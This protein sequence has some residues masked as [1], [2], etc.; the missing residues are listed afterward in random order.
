METRTWNP[1]PSLYLSKFFNFENFTSSWFLLLRRHFYLVYAISCLIAVKKLD[2]QTEVWNEEQFYTS[3]SMLYAIELDSS[4]LIW[5]WASSHCTKSAGS[6]IFRI[7]HSCKIALRNDAKVIGGSL[8]YL[9]VKL[10]TNEEKSSDT[11]PIASLCAPLHSKCRDKPQH[12][13]LQE[14]LL[15]VWL[16]WHCRSLD[17]H[18][19]IRLPLPAVLV[20]HGQPASLR[21]THS[22]RSRSNLN[23]IIYKT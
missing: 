6:I 8:L 23:L 3:A 2:E 1:E 11:S 13:L 5:L 17:P 19:C 7:L 12:M 4:K 22:H 10:W 18:E 9:M 14:D 16:L 15:L 21:R 20:Q